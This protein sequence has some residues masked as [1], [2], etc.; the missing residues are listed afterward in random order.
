MAMCYLRLPVNGHGGMFPGK[1]NARKAA[2]NIQLHLLKKPKQVQARS[3]P[4][5]N[6][7]SFS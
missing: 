4:T 3:L 7:T 5:D 6:R 1:I 2:G